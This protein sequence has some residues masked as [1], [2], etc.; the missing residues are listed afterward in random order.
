MAPAAIVPLQEYRQAHVW[1]E[2]RYRLHE[3]FD[4]WLDEVEDKVS[5]E[6]PNLEEIV[7]TAFEDRDK[8]TGMVAESLIESRYAD[9]LEQQTMS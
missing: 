7:Q 6:R 1:R 9:A 8:L 2:A 5:E 3:Q 4:E